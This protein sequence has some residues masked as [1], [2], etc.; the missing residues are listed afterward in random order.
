[1]DGE[2]V[3]VVAGLVLEVGDDLGRLAVVP[4][5]PN[6]RALTRATVRLRPASP[7]FARA[8]FGILVF[9]FAAKSSSAGY[10]ILLCCLIAAIAIGMVG[11]MR[12]NNP[13]PGQ[14][15]ARRRPAPRLPLVLQWPERHP[16]A[17]GAIDQ[18]AGQ[19]DNQ[20]PDGDHERSLKPL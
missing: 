19:N 20:H 4:H 8:I 10:L 18:G 12:R 5:A 6:N 3:G 1:M 7:R 14:A 15:L 17:E 2:G 16:H 11:V 13:P 9:A